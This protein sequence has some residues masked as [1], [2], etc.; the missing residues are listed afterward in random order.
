MKRKKVLY[1]SI[2]KTFKKL[3]HVE[4]NT[5]GKS[6]GVKKSKKG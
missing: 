5:H 4:T 3:L 2:P 6:L 1:D